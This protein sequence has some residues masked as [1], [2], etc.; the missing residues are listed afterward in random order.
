ML[1][2]P[3][4]RDKRARAGVVDNTEYSTAKMGVNSRVMVCWRP[5]VWYPAKKYTTYFC[6]RPTNVLNIA[7]KINCLASCMQP[8]ISSFSGPLE[9]WDSKDELMSRLYLRH[10]KRF[11]LFTL[12]TARDHFPFSVS[13]TSLHVVIVDFFFCEFLHFRISVTV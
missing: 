3:S 13:A 2:S 7:R 6:V 11:Y 8:S 9:T 10:G 4:S 12:R 1:A 5:W